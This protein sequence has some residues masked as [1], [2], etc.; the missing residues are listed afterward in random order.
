MAFY[1]G[2]IKIVCV[3]NKRT[4]KRGDTAI[5]P[6]CPKDT[7]LRRFTNEK[8]IYV[9]SAIVFYVGVANAS[10]CLRQ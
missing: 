2:T 5:R 7:F 6:K 1:D 4:Q 10:F 3:E 8:S 9:C